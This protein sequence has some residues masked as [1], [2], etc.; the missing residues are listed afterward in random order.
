MKKQNNP[1]AKAVE[2]GRQAETERR[3]ADKALSRE[4]SQLKALLNICQMADTQIQEIGSFVIEECI[5][6]SGSELGFFGFINED[7]TLMTAHLWSEKV[8][9]ACAVDNKPVEFPCGNAGIWAEAIRQ[10]KPVIV[11]DYDKPDPRKKGCPEG[12]VAL[13]RLMS[14]PIIE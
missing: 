5:R 2:L 10:R 6:I 3:R 13:S 8:I 14:I 9:E 1:P 12:H 7:E 11:N 4:R